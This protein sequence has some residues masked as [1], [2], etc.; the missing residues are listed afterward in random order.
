MTWPE[1]C[2]WL[3]GLG[4][5][6]VYLGY[7][8]LIAAAAHC[9]GRLPRR[10]GPMPGSLSIVIAARNEEAAIARRIREL[11]GLIAAAGIPGEIIIVSDGSTDRTAESAE[12]DAGDDVQIIDLEA[13]L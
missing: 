1:L 10:V 12:V 4:V 11:R 5:A 9:F 3:C 7:P 2:F 6:Y 8:L 13:T